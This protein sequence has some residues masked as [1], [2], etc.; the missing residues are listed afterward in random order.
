MLGAGLLWFGWFGFNAGSALAANGIA[1]VAFI[2]TLV[3]AA[4][5]DARLADRRADPRRPRHHARRGLRRRRRP[6]RDHPGLRPRR[7]PVGAIAIGLVAGVVCALAVGLKYKF[8]YDDSLD[9]VGVHLV[10]GSSARSCSASSPRD[11][12]R[13]AGGDGLFY[14]GGVDQ[15]GKQVVARWSPCW[16]YSFVLTLIIGY[17]RQ[18]HDRP[19]GRRGGRGRRHRPGRARRDRLRAS[20]R[21]VGGPQRQQ[22]VAPPAATAATRGGATS[23]KLVTAVI[24]PFKLDDVKE[25]LESSGCRA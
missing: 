20:A 13:P 6:G 18:G 15:L 4:R 25:A 12:G 24:K 8:G 1:G 14:G 7:R 9:V 19:P 23:M 10:G 5:R 22:S 11:G 17:A 3:A 2:N 21:G 16:S